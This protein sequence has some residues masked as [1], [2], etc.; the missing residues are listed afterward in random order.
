MSVHPERVYDVT[1]LKSVL[2]IFQS[3]NSTVNIPH[4]ARDFEPV[5][6]VL[7]SEGGH[8]SDYGLRDVPLT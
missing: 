4:Q 2:C 6:E 8:Q 5:Q 1:Y 7:L 3:V